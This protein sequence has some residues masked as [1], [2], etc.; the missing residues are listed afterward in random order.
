MSYP[1]DHLHA[2]H[3]LKVLTR[4]PCKPQALMSKIKEQMEQALDGFPQIPTHRRQ[5]INAFCTSRCLGLL[6]WAPELLHL[7]EF[8]LTAVV[9]TGSVTF[10]SN[11]GDLEKFL[12]EKRKSQAGC[13]A[14]Q[15]TDRQAMLP[16]RHVFGGRQKQ[17]E[18]YPGIGRPQNFA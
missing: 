12:A 17:I 1:S 13:G 18:R 16:Q 6:G 10:G 5:A 8:Q 4:N 9:L 2:A 15:V 3:F 7:G 11:T 14:L